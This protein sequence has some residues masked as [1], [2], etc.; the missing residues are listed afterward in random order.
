MSEEEGAYI[1]GTDTAEHYRLGL[2]HQVWAEEAQK[3][4]QLAGFT[5]G[6]HLLDLGSGPGFCTKELA[7]IA[8]PRGKVTAVDLSQQY[9]EHLKQLTR[10]HNL[11][12]EAIA[13]DF[14]EMQLTPNSLDG[15]YCRWALA[16]LDNPKSIL[17]KVKSALK[18]GGKMVMQEYFQWNTHQTVPSMPSL[19]KGIAACLK[20]FKDPPGDID[21]GRFLPAIVNELNMTVLNVRLMPKIARPKDFAWNWPKSFYEV[22]FPKLVEMQYL[23]E[24]DMTK[25]LKE[26]NALEQNPNALL[27]CPLMVEV[28]AQK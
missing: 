7:F 27:F 21:V 23:S 11:N 22:Y 28:I 5:A 4:W 8:G 3:G 18:P 26:L 19:A 12:I 10:L 17:Q 24:T 6:Q 16:W 9:I 14:A 1:L 13:S 25:G 20:S 2:Q 15:M